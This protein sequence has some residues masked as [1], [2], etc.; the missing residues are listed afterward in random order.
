[1]LSTRD[2]PQTYAHLQTK[3]TG[4][5]KVFHVNGNHK[6]AEVTILLQ[7]YYQRKQTLKPKLL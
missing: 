3:I 6:K 4:W 1:M 7:Q 2:P 5:E